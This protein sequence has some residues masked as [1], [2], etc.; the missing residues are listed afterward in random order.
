ML[1]RIESTWEPQPGPQT[2]L[3][4][5]PADE[6]LFGGAVGGGKTDGILGDW[7]RHWRDGGKNARGLLT[8]QTFPELVEI[9]RRAMLLFPQIGAALNSAKHIW[10]FHDGATL[11]VGYLETVAD[12]PRYQGGEY[13]WLGVDE[14]GVHPTP[15]AIDLVSTRL[16]S[17]AGVKTRLVLT[18]NPGQA[19]H[20]WLKKRFVSPSLPGIP[21]VDPVKNVTRVFLPSRIEDNPILLKNDPTY[22][23]R[24]KGLGPGWLVRAWLMGDWDASPGSGAFERSWIRNYARA[25]AEVRANQNVYI[26]CDPAHSKRKGSDYT[27]FFVIGLAQDRNYYV[28][29]LIRDR[30]SLTERWDSL[31]RLHR[32]WKPLGVGYE[33][34]GLQADVEFFRREMERVNYRFGIVEVGGQV[35]KEERI[36]A[37]EPSMRE[38][39]WWF[40]QTILRQMATDIPGGD[41]GR[42]N[43][44]LVEAYLEELDLFPAPGVHDDMLDAQ[45]RILDPRLGAVF[46]MGDEPRTKDAYRGQRPARGG[47]GWMAR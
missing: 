20:H 12:F 10:T 39:R 42:R 19:G 7:L 30:L 46:P 31:H 5:C 28:L 8:R 41:T 11:Q 33:R 27:V 36:R 43:T 32:E 29:D 3:I 9:D 22:V 2:E 37:L 18:A 14:A 17:A 6:I 15:E 21:F 4:L 38:G 40:P 25:P 16:R 47:G 13:T 1:R 34:Y 44:N 23:D 24:L 35:A 45:A 26:V